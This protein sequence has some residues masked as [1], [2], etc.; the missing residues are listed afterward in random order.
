MPFSALSPTPPFHRNRARLILAVPLLPAILGTPLVSY[1]VVFKILSFVLGASFFGFPWLQKYSLQGLHWLNTNYPDWPE[2]LDLGRSLLRGVPTNA[3]LTL[4]LLRLAEAQDAPLP[5]PPS[6]LP[7]KKGEDAPP[8]VQGAGPRFDKG[9]DD[10]SDDDDASDSETYSAA[11]G[12]ATAASPHTDAGTTAQKKGARARIAGLLRGT[13]KLGAETVEVT[14]RVKAATTGAA[15]DKVGVLPPKIARPTRDGP[16]S[17]YGRHRGKRGHVELVRQAGADP[18]H[19]RVQFVRAGKRER[20]P[21]AEVVVGEIVELRKVGGLGWK[22]K[23]IAGWALGEDV[24]DGI[25]MRCVDGR[26]E[27]FTAM[28][29]RD[30]LF[31]R[32]IAM[33]GQKWEAL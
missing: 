18:A 14:H 8:P 3:Q 31:D 28:P 21:E 29:R 6:T 11:G 30:E 25:E 1:A 2:R 17:F 20:E 19:T 7:P 26:T 32:L 4:T 24:P 13:A 27:M 12:D 23:L 10:S 16:D 9:Y 33:G 15:R 22:G 5:P